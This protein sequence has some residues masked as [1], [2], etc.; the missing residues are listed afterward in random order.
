MGLKREG[1]GAI[2]GHTGGE[3][4]GRG[5]L[6]FF[7]SPSPRALGKEGSQSPNQL[8]RD[9]WWGEGLQPGRCSLVGCSSLSGWIDLARVEL[10]HSPS[11]S[12]FFSARRS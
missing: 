10:H 2:R 6:F 7:L 4:G 5:C 9:G 3:L 1:G 8:R 11:T 12:L